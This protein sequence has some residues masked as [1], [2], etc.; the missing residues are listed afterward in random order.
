MNENRQL[1]IGVHGATGRMGKRVCDLVHADRRLELAGAAADAASRE[2]G[3]DIGVVAGFGVCGVRVTP[4]L[5]NDLDA[6]IDFSVPD[7]SAA[8]AADCASKG[9]PIVIAT[10]GFSKEQKE[11]IERSASK[12]A[13]LVAANCSL[14][15]N[16]LLKLAETTGKILR[17]RDFD[18]EIIE[19]HHRF[20]ADAPSGT[21]LAFAR[22]LQSTM[23]LEM[24]RHGREGMTGARTSNE[25][26]LHAV[27]A[28]DNVGE[29]TIIFGA[30]GETMELVHKSSSRDSYAKGAVEAAKF[31]VGK[32]PGLY[33]MADVLG[34]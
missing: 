30:L 15:V 26:G 33:S 14:V 7:A 11:V 12:T 24:Q 13:L 1:R 16:I 8:L 17:G 23:G 6:V 31:L 34:L 18:V 19:R 21:A 32:P 20:K 3:Q 5:P 27:R 10:T 25:I 28:G 2:I 22:V 4:T 9:I 29:H